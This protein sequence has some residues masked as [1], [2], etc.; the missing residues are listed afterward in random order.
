MVTKSIL[1]AAVAV[2]MAAA[3]P[4]SVK[5]AT[6]FVPADFTTNIIGGS[7]ASEGEF[8]FIVSLQR[9]GSHLCGGSLLN[10]NTVV[11]AAHCDVGG[12]YSIRAGSLVSFLLYHLLFFFFFAVSVAN[13]MSRALPAEAPPS[14][15]PRSSTTPITAPAATTT[16]LPCGTCPSPLRRATASN[17]LLCLLP[18]LTPPRERPPLSL[19]GMFILFKPSHVRIKDHLC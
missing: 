3:A 12:T 2:P 5:K 17:T 6:S 9:S 19:D 1:A 10:A 15:F 11:T 7:P 4:A 13:L 18:A 16:T 8:P 14:A